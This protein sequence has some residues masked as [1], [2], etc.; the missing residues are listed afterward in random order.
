MYSMQFFPVENA[1][2]QI[3]AWQRS[4]N[5]RRRPVTRSGR[6]IFRMYTPPSHFCS[7]SLS[8]FFCSLLCMYVHARA[9]TSS[10]GILIFL[11]RF[12]SFSSPAFLSGKRNIYVYFDT[13]IQSG[14]TFP[15]LPNWFD[16]DPTLID[17]RDKRIS[18][19]ARG[20]M[21]E[22]TIIIVRIVYRGTRAHSILAP[23]AAAR[24]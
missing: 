13:Y 5:S 2:R 23:S 7:H 15:V 18:L 6:N 3:F 4:I 24:V 12:F 9:R 20:T 19:T 11:F 10:K 17:L 8:L 14:Q 1:K 21:W 16:G 22:Y